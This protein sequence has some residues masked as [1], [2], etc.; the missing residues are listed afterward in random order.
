MC[1]AVTALL[2]CEPFSKSKKSEADIRSS[3]GGSEGEDSRL[4]HTFNVAYD[5]L[6]AN[7]G[8]PSLSGEYGG[9]SGHIEGSDLSSLV[10][11]SDLSNSNGLGAG[12]KMALALQRTIISTAISLVERKAIQRLT[13]FRYAYL[14]CTSQ[15]PTGGLGH[16]LTFGSIKSSRNGLNADTDIFHIFTKPLALTK[17]ANF[18]M[19]MHRANGKW[20]GVRASPL[21][22][23]AENPQTQTYVV[24]GYECQEH[25]DKNRFGQNFV[26]A[27]KTMRGTFKFDSFDSNVVEVRATEVQKFI[28]QLHYVMEETK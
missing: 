26:L 2:E 1:Y 10:N 6:N 21:I 14:N 20:A 24:V 12:L 9:I 5:A 13:H 25:S 28:E 4:I 16:G 15:G 8:L 23:M 7:G 11:G 17:L 18:L 27:A 3:N 22:L 19:D